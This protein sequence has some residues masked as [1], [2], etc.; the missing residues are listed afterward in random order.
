ME[1][2]QQ[3]EKQRELKSGVESGQGV[4]PNP[5]PN[6]N[7]HPSATDALD[8]K[9]L[10][11]KIRSNEDLSNLVKF[12]FMGM[13]CGGIYGITKRRIDAKNDDIVLHPRAHH[14]GIEPL[15]SKYF[16]ELAQFRL[17][18]ET[19]YCESI[20]QADLLLLIESQ[21]VAAKTASET[22][23]TLAEMRYKCA[24]MHLYKF[25]ESIGTNGKD[26]ALVNALN[27]QIGSILQEHLTRVLKLTA[28][29]RSIY[30]WNRMGF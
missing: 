8:L 23:A 30:S 9:K 27:K 12:M 26:R 4:L 21:I 3:N 7:P 11:E 22:D 24:R 15:L 17:A 19:S 20:R 28:P 25:S 1:Q 18:N 14:F 10:R 29:T 13:I 2:Q 6:S 16:D 5:N